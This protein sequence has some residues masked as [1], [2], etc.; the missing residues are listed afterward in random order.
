KTIRQIFRSN[1]FGQQLIVRSNEKTKGNPILGHTKL[2]LH[3]LRFASA[4][5]SSSQFP[6]LKIAAEIIHVLHF[7]VFIGNFFLLTRSLTPTTAMDEYHKLQ[8]YLVLPKILHFL[9]VIQ[10][11]DR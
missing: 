5:L 2:R 4:P 6:G 11:D 3:S 10:P 8:G 9:T 1:Y 7:L